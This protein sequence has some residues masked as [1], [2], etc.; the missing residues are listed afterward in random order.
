MRFI[1]GHLQVGD[2]QP[3]GPVDGADILHFFLQ[4]LILFFH[5]Q[6]FGPHGGEQLHGGVKALAR[7]GLG[8][9]KHAVILHLIAHLIEHIP[10]HHQQH[11]NVVVGQIQRQARA[12]LI[13]QR[14]V[15]HHQIHGG[16]QRKAANFAHAGRKHRGLVLIF[17]QKRR[18][19][20]AQLIVGAGNKNTIFSFS[21]YHGS[22]SFVLF[23]LL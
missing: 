22:H 23:I 17:G 5:A 2:Q 9:R 8:Q 7:N 3:F 1:L 12:E 6:H 20:L 4:G 15:Q 10:L 16:F 21:C 11:R 14:R 13:F 19:A 18:N